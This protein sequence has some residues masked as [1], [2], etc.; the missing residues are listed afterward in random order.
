M[1]KPRVVVCAAIKFTTEGRDFLVCSA[2]H[3]D[4]TMVEQ[5]KTIGIVAFNAKMKY[6]QGFIDQYGKFMTREE[7]YKVAKE[8][9]QIK[10]KC[11]GDENQLFSEN[12]Y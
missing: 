6:E 10:Y 8:A 4:Q 9:N 12:L 1:N 7:A 2:R 3:Y 5:I 11:G